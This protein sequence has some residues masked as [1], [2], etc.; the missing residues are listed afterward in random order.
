MNN[1]KADKGANLY[2]AIDREIKNNPHK[3]TE[4]AATLQ[5]CNPDLLE[6][7]GKKIESSLSSRPPLEELLAIPVDDIWF[8]F[9]LWLGLDEKFLK[10][11]CDKVKSLQQD[12]YLVTSSVFKDMSHVSKILMFGITYQAISDQ[13]PGDLLTQYHLVQALLNI[14]KIT[15]AKKMLH[16]TLSGKHKL[17]YV[18][19]AR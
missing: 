17:K 4:L 8:L 18:G 14:G 19:Q 12:T 7:F 6:I 1:T 16:D 11:I 9:G 13:T 5:S 2:S 3:F 15:E 10:G